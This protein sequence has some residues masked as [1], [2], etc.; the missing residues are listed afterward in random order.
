MEREETKDDSYVFLLTV[1]C[2]AMVPFFGK[3]VYGKKIGM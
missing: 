3:S 1:G 2:M